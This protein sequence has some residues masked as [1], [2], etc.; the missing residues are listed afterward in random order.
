MFW[1]KVLKFS[2]FAASLI[3]Y[4]FIKERKRI[5]QRFTSALG[6]FGAVH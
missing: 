5:Q 3:L 1:E 6:R 2:S 4:S